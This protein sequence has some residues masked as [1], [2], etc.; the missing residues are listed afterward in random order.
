M[1]GILVVVDRGIAISPRLLV[2]VEIV[3]VPTD[4]FGNLG[5]VCT[6]VGLAN[7]LCHTL[8]ISSHHAHPA[9]KIHVQF[10]RMRRLRSRI[11]V[12]ARGQDVALR[13][14]TPAIGLP[15]REG[16]GVV[17][18]QITELSLLVPLKVLLKLRVEFPEET[19]DAVRTRQSIDRKVTSNLLPSVE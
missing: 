8:D 2:P 5:I 9:D 3:Y 17:G 11:V 6:V 12:E 18:L 4:R 16:R 13:T 10:T 1:H 14:T 15:G 7:V 19:A